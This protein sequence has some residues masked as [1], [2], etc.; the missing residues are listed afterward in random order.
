MKKLRF[1]SLLLALSLLLSLPVQAAE[2]SAENFVR[3]K[4]YQDHFSDLSPLSIFYDNITALY[5]Y[6]LSIGRGDGT[7]GVEDPLTVG[8]T[9]IFAARI[10]CLYETGSPE[11]RVLP[12]V[13]PESTVRHPYLLYLKDRGLLGDELD[14]LLGKNATRAEMAHVLARLLP[15]EVLPPI[16]EAL[17]NE[18]FA[19]HRFIPDV[20]EYT[21]YFQD[22][23]QLYRTGISQGNDSRVISSS[24]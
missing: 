4:T 3:T 16:N 6:G 13:S 8:D 10:R 11:P 19:T 23:L 2:Y 12:L 18:S 5:E 22:I 15:P 1:L 21:P 24:G 17:V 20:T 7:F 9:I 14:N